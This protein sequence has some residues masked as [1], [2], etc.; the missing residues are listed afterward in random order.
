M[1]IGVI[2]LGCPK[3]LADT[4]SVVSFI[5]DFK[6]SAIKDAD[7]V[8]LNTC[9]FLKKSRDE[10]F[11]H[12]N[13][14]KNKKVIILGCLASKFTKNDL[15]KYKQIFAVVSGINYTNIQAILNSIEKGNK[16]FAVS[17]EPEIYELE[18]GKMLLSSSAYAYVKIAEGCNNKCSYC[19][20]PSLKGKYRSRKME[21]I[22]LE[23]KN[24][25]KIGIKEIIL[26]AQDCGP[27]GVDLYGEKKLPDLLK[28]LEAIKGKFWIRML[29]IYPETIDE[30]L[31]KVIK[32]SKKILRY[33]DIPLQHGD[34][35]IL[36]KMNRPSDINKTLKKTTAIKKTLPGVT[37]RT[38]L[39]VGFPGETE[40]AFQ[41][42]KSFVEKINFDHVGVFEYSREK[43]TVSYSLKPQIPERIKQ[44]RRK[45]IMLL[46]QKISLE[47]NKK[48]IGKTFEILIENFDDKKKQYIGRIPRFAPEI[49]GV[50]YLKSTKKL[51]LNEFYKT[52]IKTADEYDLSGILI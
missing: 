16:V 38:S 45:E 42:L 4:E 24:L 5:K 49:D 43:G 1:E 46:Q 21:D 11:E 7:V 9:G 12:L 35:G 25:I 33:L 51:K 44:K 50:V 8:L 14:L 27:Y 28:K 40:K 52:K 41:N 19:L 29:Y 15:K 23:V 20:I 31:L 13:K 17:K 34:P 36:K 6:L 18:G 22:I 30:K 48:L 2:S 39:I 3:N 10:V 32:S 26:V 37:L 47:N